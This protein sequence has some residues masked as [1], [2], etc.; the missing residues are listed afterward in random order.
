LKNQQ[1]LPGKPEGVFVFWIADKA[2]LTIS[3]M[4][5]FTS[6]NGMIQLKKKQN[7][8]RFDINREAAEKVHLKIN[9]KLL[10]LADNPQ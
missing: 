8:M 7:T 3:D 1:P 10:K 6:A 9:S 2:I 4:E 5:G